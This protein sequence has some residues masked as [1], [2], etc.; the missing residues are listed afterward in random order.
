MPTFPWKE[1]LTE[2]NKELL[3]DVEFIES[4]PTEVV[5]SGWLGYPGATETEIAEAEARLGRRL[6]PSCREFFQLTNGWRKTPFVGKVWS[7]REIDW[8]FVRNQQWIDSYLSKYADS[9]SISDE[10][11]FVYGDAQR[12]PTIRVEYLQNTLEISDKG[13]S[14]IYLLNPQVITDEGEWEAWF[15][16]D[17]LP[18]AKR[19]RSFWDLMEGE[20]A[21]WICLH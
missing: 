1:L 6:P 17:W 13:D 8:F 4:L 14:V 18:G 11:Y 21:E 20:Y 10:A 9:S 3:E 16:A 7:T 15:F 12:D 5:A 2:W 19:Y